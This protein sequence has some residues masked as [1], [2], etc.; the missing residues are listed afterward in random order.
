MSIWFLTTFN[1]T[2]KTPLTRIF[3]MK[4]FVTKIFDVSEV[5]GIKSKYKLDFNDHKKV[6]YFKKN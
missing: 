1:F 5:K 2:Q 6:T 4:K 3:L